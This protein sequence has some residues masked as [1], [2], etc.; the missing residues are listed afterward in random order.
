L[1]FEIGTRSIPGTS[2]SISPKRRAKATCS[3]AR[4]CW[5]GKI[6]TAWAWKAVSTARQSSGSSAA[7]RTP[8]T[9]APRVASAG[10]ISQAM[11]GFE[12][13]ARAI[14]IAV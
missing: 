8:R 5:P 12:H 14:S 3:P 11:M 4:R 1:R 13:P 9:T 10:W 6:K 7:S 2:C